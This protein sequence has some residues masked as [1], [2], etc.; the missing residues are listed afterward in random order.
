MAEDLGTTEPAVRAEVN[1]L[2]RRFRQLLRAEIAETI[3]CV[4][5]VDEELRAIIA[6]LRGP[7]R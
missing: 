4:A 1:R 2:R 5:E 7:E 6:A 3:A